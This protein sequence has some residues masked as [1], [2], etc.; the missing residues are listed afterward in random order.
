MVAVL[1][2]LFYC[3]CSVV[4]VLGY[5]LEVTVFWGGYPV[6]DVLRSLFGGGCLVVAVW[7]WL[8]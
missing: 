3:G 1:W 4:A 5:Y 2:L 7:W 6:A 8:F